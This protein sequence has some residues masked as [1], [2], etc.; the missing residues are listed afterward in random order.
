MHTI[1]IAVVGVVIGVVVV[2]G[3]CLFEELNHSTILPFATA[4]GLIIVEIGL[5]LAGGVFSGDLLALVRHFRRKCG[6]RATP[7]A[8]RERERERGEVERVSE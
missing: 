5:A 7:I 8:C 1:E 6:E 3:S 4:A 2:N